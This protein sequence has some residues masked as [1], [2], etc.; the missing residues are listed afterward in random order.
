[1]RRKRGDR[2][3][4]VR[5]EGEKNEFCYPHNHTDLSREGWPRGLQGTISFTISTSR[6][7]RRETCKL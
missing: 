2:E 6:L 3:E 4:G 7:L 5:E 1:M